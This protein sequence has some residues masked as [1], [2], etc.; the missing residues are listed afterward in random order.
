MPSGIRQATCP[1]VGARLRAR[2]HAGAG[3]RSN[4][5][6][7]AN[8]ALRGCA[9]PLLKKLCFVRGKNIFCSAGN[10]IL[11]EPASESKVERRVDS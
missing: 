7:A 4:P 11:L 9:A 3:K 2:R 8:K 6:E 10:V 5:A 1:E